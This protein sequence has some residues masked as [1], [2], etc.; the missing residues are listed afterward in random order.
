MINEKVLVRINAVSYAI[1]S[2]FGLLA[3][4]WDWRP[5]LW[6]YWLNTISAVLVGAVRAAR[7]SHKGARLKAGLS[8]IREFIFPFLPVYGLFL[9]LPVYAFPLDEEYAAINGVMPALKLGQIL[10]I[11]VLQMTVEIILACV[12]NDSGGRRE[13]KRDITE[14]VEGRVGSTH[15]GI[16]AGYFLIIPFGGHLYAVAIGLIIINSFI[17]YLSTLDKKKRAKIQSPR[18]SS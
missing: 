12:G 2:A 13:R 18:K 4:G 15:L 1:V 14:A 17:S 16:I 10:A 5:I 9:L 8:I 7:V 11:W 3:L 6:L